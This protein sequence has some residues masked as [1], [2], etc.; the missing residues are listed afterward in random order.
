MTW[1]LFLF[2]LL[3]AVAGMTLATQGSTAQE[4]VMGAMLT[5]TGAAV[6]VLATLL[7]VARPLLDRLAS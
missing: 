6:M 7:H 5:R 2:G 1:A 3:I 4:G